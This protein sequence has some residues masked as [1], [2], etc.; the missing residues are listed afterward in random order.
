MREHVQQLLTERVT[1]R[2]V[3]VEPRRPKREVA[4]NES[5]GP[6]LRNAPHHSVEGRV[7]DQLV[8]GADQEPALARQLE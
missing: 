8:P 6:Q 2:S 1:H 3:R 4:V 7:T 5:D